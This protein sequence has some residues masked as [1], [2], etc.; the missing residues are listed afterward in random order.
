[1]S[2][3]AIPVVLTILNVV[4]ENAKS[5]ALNLSVFDHTEI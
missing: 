1:M 3:A 2:V 5:V 4:L